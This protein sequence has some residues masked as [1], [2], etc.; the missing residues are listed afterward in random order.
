MHSFLIKYL[1]LGNNSYNNIIKKWNHEIK[2][3]LTFNIYNSKGY[4]DHKF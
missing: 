1:Y 3:F 4:D 2:Y